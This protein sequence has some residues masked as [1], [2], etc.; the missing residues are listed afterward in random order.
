MPTVSDPGYRLIRAAIEAGIAVE[1]NPGISAV[2]TALVV[3]GLPAVPF[4][5]HG[6]LPHKSTARR[7]VLAH[8]APL[9]Q[10]L[11]FFESPYRLVKTLH[12]IHE[13]FGDRR[14]VMARELT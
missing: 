7:K 1:V 11:V 10:T 3:S 8:H 13:I 5:F 2:T 9:P 6:F 14:I 12:D 4:L